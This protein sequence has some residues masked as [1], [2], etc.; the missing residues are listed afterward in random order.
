MWKILKDNKCA[1]YF[2][3]FKIFGIFEVW[4]STLNV[5]RSWGFFKF[6]LFE[7]WVSWGLASWN[8]DLRSLKDICNIM[9][10]H[11]TKKT[12][13]FKQIKISSLNF[14]AVKMYLLSYDIWIYSKFK[15]GQVEVRNMIE[16]FYILKFLTKLCHD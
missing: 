6:K 11:R 9:A 7:S 16:I 10:M 4:N 2:F 8:L 14:S 13:K 12:A 5:F 15:V 3:Y 1:H